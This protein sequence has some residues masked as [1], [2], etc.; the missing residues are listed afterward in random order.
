VTDD[1]Q[2][3][4]LWLASDADLSDWYTA[5]TLVAATGPSDGPEE[6]FHEPHR[7]VPTPLVDVRAGMASFAADYPSVVAKLPSTA[8]LLA[9][10]EARAHPVPDFPEEPRDWGSPAHLYWHATHPHQGHG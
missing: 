4:E 5:M 6:G 2:V 7:A 1:V 3:R 10:L 8:E 9:V